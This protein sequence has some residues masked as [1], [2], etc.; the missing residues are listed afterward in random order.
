MSTPSTTPPPAT[1]VATRRSLHAV[2]EL[3]MAGPQH[4]LA[5]TIRLA[6]TSDGFSTVA[7][8]GDPSRLEVR[9]VSL[10]VNRPSGTVIEPLAGT[11]AELADAVGVEP[12]APVGVYTDTT[13]ADEASVV[14]VDEA[15]ARTILAALA[16][17]DEALR[18]FAA[19]HQGQD[20][21]PP[22]LWPEHFDVGISLD[23]VNYG[24]SPGD[25]FLAE[26]YAYV[27][28][29][30]PRRGLFWSQPFGAAQPMSSLADDEALMG[31]FEAGRDAAATDPPA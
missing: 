4:R 25:S 10:L 12:G 18:R 22:V 20:P 6:V 29:W 31:F 5:G 1:L 21:P 2:A 13:G 23:E 9:G 26:P 7:L 15:A 3:L 14:A 30:S 16:R 27:G 8:T 24:V 11:I 28:P 17:G 19:R